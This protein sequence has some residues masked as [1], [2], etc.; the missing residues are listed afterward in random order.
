MKLNFRKRSTRPV[1]RLDITPL[2][3]VIFLL[4]IFFMLT[5]NYVLQA[6]L[7]VELPTAVD[8]FTVPIQRIE[9]FIT[10]NDEIYCKGIRCTP[11]ELLA[12]LK[13]EKGTVSTVLILADVDSR[14]GRVVQV[15]DVCRRSGFTDISVATKPG[16]LQR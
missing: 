8:A 12:M 16:D 11:D 4:I 9:V 1:R 6:G 3:D 10:S 5:S 7:K 2:I 14:H 13:R 15:E